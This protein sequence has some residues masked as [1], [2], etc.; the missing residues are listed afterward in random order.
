MVIMAV[1]L[2]ILSYRHLE[3][4]YSEIDRLSGI[5]DDVLNNEDT[6]WEDPLAE[7]SIGVL[8][9]NF[10]KMVHMFREGKKKELSEKELIEPLPTQEIGSFR[11]TK[12]S[13]DMIEVVNKDSFIPE[14][15]MMSIDRINHA[16]LESIGADEKTIE[17]IERSLKKSEDEFGKPDRLTNLRKFAENALNK[18]GQ[19][20]EKAGS[21]LSKGDIPS[22]GD[23]R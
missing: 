17:S 4:P 11:V 8:Y 10:G 1:V 6:T 20:I 21:V 19:A 14:P 2:G 23:G 5:M 12:V 16:K 3:K 22:R 13:S 9:S 15:A 7:G 18:A